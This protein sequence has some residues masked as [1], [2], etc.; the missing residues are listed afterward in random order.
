MLRVSAY[1]FLHVKPKYVS[2]VRKYKVLFGIEGPSVCLFVAVLLK[3]PD[4]KAPTTYS[5][6]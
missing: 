3:R 2:R 4:T 6:L 5:E 1:F